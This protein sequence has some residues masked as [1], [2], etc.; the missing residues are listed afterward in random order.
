[1]KP[2]KKEVDAVAALLVAGDETPEK[3][4]TRVIEALDQARTERVTYFSV[5]RFGD[6][7]NVFF[8][9]VGPFS[10]RNQA[11][12]AVEKHPAAGMARGYAVVPTLTDEGLDALIASVDETPKARS[13]WAEV[14][15][16]AAAK[17]NGWTGKAATRGRYL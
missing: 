2:L 10:T 13:D 17:R 1:M 15:Q 14:E 11:V 16:D 9:G 4:A 8:Q 5:F 7:G 12:K 3:L 6:N